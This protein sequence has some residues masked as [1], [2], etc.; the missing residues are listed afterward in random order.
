MTTVTATKN[1]TSN[2]VLQAASKGV[3]L[4][5]NTSHGF[6]VEN[7]LLRASLTARDAEW[8]VNKSSN[9]KHKGRPPSQFGSGTQRNDGVFEWNA[10]QD[11]RY[12]HDSKDFE[13][14]LHV[15]NRQW[16]GIRAAAGSLPGNKVA[17]DADGSPSRADCAAFLL[18]C[19]DLRINRYVFHGMSTAIAKLIHYLSANGLSSQL[20]IIY[21]GNVVQWC[22]GPERELALKAIE[23]AQTGAVSRIHFL[24]KDHNIFVSKAYTPILLNMSPALPDRAIEVDSKSALVPGTTDWRKNLHC[25]ALGAA[26]TPEIEKVIHYSKSIQLPEPFSTKLQQTE[27]INRETTLRLMSFCRATLNVSLVECHPM[28]S[29][30]SEAVGTPCL[31]NKLMLDIHED[32]PYVQLVEV[33]DASSPLEISKKLTRILSMNHRETVELIK[34]YLTLINRTAQTRYK[35]FLEL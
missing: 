25:N 10:E 31:R 4:V 13:Q 33:N 16:I 24:K 26:I 32:H 34:D 21:H 3:S 27:P 11:T 22:Y 23:L 5:S 28:V 19:S 8:L 17:V 15:F 6:D 14:V 29:L 30:E 2:R 7:A 35:E 20:F 1:Q 18:K 9:P 12:A